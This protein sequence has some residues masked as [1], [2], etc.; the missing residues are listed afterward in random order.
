MERQGD[1]GS[2][3]AGAVGVTHNAKDEQRRTHDEPFRRT[4]RA[5]C[6]IVWF[7]YVRVEGA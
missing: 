2:G 7:A 6:S 4:P 1:E 5:V 3:P